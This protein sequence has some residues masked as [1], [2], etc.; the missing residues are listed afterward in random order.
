MYIH[1]ATHLLTLLTLLTLLINLR[2][3]TYSSTYATHAI[4]LHQPPQLT[5]YIY[6][7]MYIYIYIY[8]K[9]TSLH[10]G[11]EGVAE[12]LALSQKMFFLLFQ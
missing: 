6:I 2:Y 3:L 7:Y 9:S 10:I 12:F 11:S 4:A 1:D 8:I 5:I